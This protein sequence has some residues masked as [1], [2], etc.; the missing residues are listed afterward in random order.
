MM[1]QL[2]IEL[3]QGG[4]VGTAIGSVIGT[5]AGLLYIGYFIKKEKR[6]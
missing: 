1:E 4:L 3:I 6:K 5:I 2:L